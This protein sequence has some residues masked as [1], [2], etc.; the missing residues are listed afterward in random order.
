MPK[1]NIYKLKNDG[2]QEIVVTAVLDGDK[3][4]FSG[5]EL[6][7]KN[8]QTKGILDYKENT[9][10]KLYPKDGKIFLEN[11]KYNFNSGYFNATDI[12]Y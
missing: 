4:N 11:L 9:N 7:I 5:D 6:F 3:I 12:E 1:V 10:K 8:L 2:N